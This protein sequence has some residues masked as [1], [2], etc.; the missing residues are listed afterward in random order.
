MVLV[1]FLWMYSLVQHYLLLDSV[2]EESCFFMLMTAS[3]MAVTLTPR[4][5]RGI[6][7]IWNTPNRQRYFH[8]F[9]VF[10]LCLYLAS[11]RACHPSVLA[12]A[13]ARRPWV[14]M[15]S[16]MLSVIH[17]SSFVSLLLRGVSFLYLMGATGIVFLF[18]KTSLRVP[19]VADA[20]EIGGNSPTGSRLAHCDKS[21]GLCQLGLCLDNTCM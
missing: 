5:H 7:M 16:S 11:L 3:M 2:S 19:T 1:F 14:A 17:E 13:A 8:L 15:L 10:A 6:Q 9:G 21:C 12:N 4:F 18:W 20:K